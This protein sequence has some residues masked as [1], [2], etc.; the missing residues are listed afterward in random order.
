MKAVRGVGP[1]RRTVWE[2]RARR[3]QGQQEDALLHFEIG[4]RT[5]AAG[6]PV[7]WGYVCWEMARCLM[8]EAEASALEDGARAAWANARGA[9]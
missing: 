3:L 1:P 6:L 4:A 8:D 9:N 7:D 5:F 2:Q